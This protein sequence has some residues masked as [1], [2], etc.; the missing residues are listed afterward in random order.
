MF[1]YLCTTKCF[2]KYNTPSFYEH[3]TIIRQNFR[4]KCFDFAPLFKLVARD[5]IYAYIIKAHVRRLVDNVSL[6]SWVRS[7]VLVS[8]NKNVRCDSQ[9]EEGWYKAKKLTS[10]G[11]CTYNFIL[12]TV[13]FTFGN[14]FIENKYPKTIVI[15]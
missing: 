2:S 5:E 6:E 8:Y 7:Y 15:F 11:V 3:V 10:I 13:L 9:W 12:K 1:P 4:V 14:F